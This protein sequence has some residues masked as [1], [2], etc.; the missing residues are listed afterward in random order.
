MEKY[1]NIVKSSEI[2]KL[3]D[4]KMYQKALM[5]LNTIDVGRVK[6]LTDLSV[7]AEVYM[8]TGHYSE[9]KK[10]L[11]RIR[12]KS[13]SRRVV[14]Q[15][16]KLAIK[17]QNVG[18]AEAY[19]KE[20]VEIAPRDTEKFI[21]RYR[22]DR[23]K[24]QGFEVLIQSLEKLKEHDYIEKW[25]YEL[26][27]LYHKAGMK[28]KCIR[29][30]SDII[31]WF[32]E[33][34]IVEKA[35]M[36]KAMYVEEPVHAESVSPEK[37]Q[38]MLRMQEIAKTK[39]LSDVTLK[40]NEILNQEE[41]KEVKE[42]AKE[43]AEQNVSVGVQAEVNE[44]V[45][46][47]VP[48]EP[49][50]EIQEE[51]SE[52]PVQEEEKS[53]DSSA[54]I[55]KILENQANIQ[56]NHKSIQEIPKDGESTVDYEYIYKN[57]ALQAI[58]KQRFEFAGIRQQIA[59]YLDQALKAGQATSFAIAGKEVTHCISLAKEMAKA[60]QELHIFETCRLAKITAVKLN[61]IKLADNYNRLKDS[62]VVIEQASL[63]TEECQSDIIKMLADMEGHIIVILVDSKEDLTSCFGQS[64]GFNSCF[65]TIL[66]MEYK[67]REE[68]MDLAYH[69]FETSE[70]ELEDE[71][72]VCLETAC[73]QIAVNVID[74]ERL[75][76]LRKLIEGVIE[77]AEIRNL[78][79]VTLSEGV[80]NYKDSQINKIIAQDF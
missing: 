73:N 56:Y 17:E 54:N 51:V 39:D 53:M 27:K 21:L 26:A 58:F 30:C 67:T 62:F 49:L 10:L 57:E 79:E 77:K 50:E 31:L 75:S 66:E 34:V 11:L 40:V 63:L 5:I 25:S 47:E 3:V 18:E 46:I 70:F 33:G 2:R 6:I 19:Y 74:I 4:N 29:E 9:A 15:L 80:I 55:Q 1:D 44:E 59:A 48:I 68:L 38:E 64:K 41:T 36:L 72:K 78:T 37:K 16:I 12:S 60:I 28:E 42:E 35:K 69:L 22:I 65:P 13:N 52:R 24:G 45:P 7:Y 43:E 20:Y 32:G 71:A 8:Q 14:G 76:S 23:M 61:K